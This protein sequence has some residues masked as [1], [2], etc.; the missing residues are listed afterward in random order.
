M[1]H[2]FLKLATIISVKQITTSS[3]LLDFLYRHS[4]QM[5]VTKNQRHYL[6]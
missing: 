1:V 4:L 3:H 6:F 2:G 5:S